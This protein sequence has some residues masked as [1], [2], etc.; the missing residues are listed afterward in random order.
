MKILFLGDV[1]GKAGRVAVAT[2][3]P[4]IIKQHG[5]DL[6]V[7]NGENATHGFGIGPDVAEE[8]FRLRVDVITTGNHAFDRAEVLDYFP[9]QS[10]LIR[11]INFPAQVPGAGVA[12]GD[13]AGGKKFLVV[14]V[15]GQLFMGG[16]DDP[17]A[18]LDKIIGTGNPRAQGYD[19]IM[20]DVHAEASSEKQA[21]GHYLDG[22]VSM[23]V[24]THTHVP[25][26][27][28]RV[29]EHGTAY[30][31]DAGMCGCY[32][33]VIG[34]EKG[35]VLKRFLKQYPLPRLEPAS[36]E[37]QVRGLLATLDAATGLATAV[38]RIAV[39]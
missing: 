15:M 8:L 12:S 2:H 5:P 37:A 16:Y 30:Q 22:R 14:N 36:G 38:E 26:A 9:L 18:A 21:I 31:T 1:V 32:D 19:I 10:R 35:K 33:S 27:D 13:T 11:P 6:V 17:F 25:T 29:L 4:K 7:V 39:G 3:L 28:E 20:V 23:V 24:G 34:M